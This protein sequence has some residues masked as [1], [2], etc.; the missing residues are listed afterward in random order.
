MSIT[1]ARR[2][3]RRAFVLAAAAALG[4][5]RPGLRRARAAGGT[6]FLWGVGVRSSPRSSPARTV[7][8]A[9]TPGSA[10]RNRATLDFRLARAAQVDF[11]VVAHRGAGENGSTVQTLMTDSQL[12]GPGRHSFVWGPGDDA[13]PGTYV[14]RIGATDLRG[15]RI[16]YREVAPGGRRRNRAPVVRVV[17]VDAAFARRSFAPAEHATLVV[18]AEAA[19]LT[20]ELL[21]CGPEREPTYS[22][23]EMKG[24]PVAEPLEI[25]W[26]HPPGEPAAI[27]V[28]VGDWPSG[29]YCARVTGDTG[30]IGFAPFVLRPPRPRE[31]IA[32]VLPTY[33]WQAYNFFDADADGF[34]DSWYVSTGTST[35]DLT[36]PHVNR[37]VPYRYRSYDLAFLRWLSRTQTAVD[38][39]ADD[40][41]EAFPSGDALRAAYD[42][43]VFPGHSEYVTAHAYDVVERFR[44]LGGNLLFLSANNFFRRVDRDGD[45][46]RLVGLWRDLGRPE[47][48]LAGVQYRASDRGQHQAPFTVTG[49]SVAPWAFEGTGLADGATFG[50]YGIEI[51]SR[52][53]ASPPGTQVLARIPNLLGSGRSAEMTYYEAPSGA[54]VFSAGVLNFGGQLELWPQ[55]LKLFENVWARLAETS[56]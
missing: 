20:V 13:P 31:R 14:L 50:L 12:F 17:G 21:R 38:Y 34:G 5:F 25:D 45:R 56:G 47:A 32:V 11:A 52:A 49:A 46:V 24:V 15:E 3:G 6:P 30:L 1:T 27:D 23:N 39:Y 37:G 35:I 16:D 29:L 42:L 26:A 2:V 44:D 36:R 10:D 40:D 53:A 51:D 48:A 9:H 18:A 54:R 55:P 8:L 4:A 19:A 7:A 41:L 43:L 28:P 33:T 22:N